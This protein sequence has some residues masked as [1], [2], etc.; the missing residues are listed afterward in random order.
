MAI[1][2]RDAWDDIRNTTYIGVYLRSHKPQ[3]SNRTRS[4]N[5]FVMFVMGGD[6]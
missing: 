6:G 3:V 1:G 2:E 4:K 5:S